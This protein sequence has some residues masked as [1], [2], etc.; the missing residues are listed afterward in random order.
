M[1]FTFRPMAI[2]DYE[3]AFALWEKTPGMVLNQSDSQE[4]VRKFLGRNPG[5]SFVCFDGETLI[6]SVL[7]GHDGKRG[8]L[9]HAAVDE[10]YRGSGI[11]RELITRCLDG[12]KEEEIIRC[13]LFV[14]EDNE[15]GSLYWER[16]GW[17]KRD[18]ILLF[19]KDT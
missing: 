8:F 11:G 3:A 16:S 17:T 4:A 14:L 9:Y 15:L 2:D 18:G 13:Y 1:R 12:L 5:L 19:S 10:D 6:G 7:C